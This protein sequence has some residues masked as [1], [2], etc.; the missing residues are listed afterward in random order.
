MDHERGNAGNGKP[1]VGAKRCASC[2]EEKPAT[3][4]HFN[5]KLTGLAAR[6]REC[7]SRER[8]AES[9]ARPPDEIEAEKAKRRAH[10]A[11]NADAARERDRARYQRRRQGILEDRRWR[12]HN[13]PDFRARRDAQDRARY[14]K[15]RDFLVQQI[16]EAKRKRR[17]VMTSD[18]IEAERRYFREWAARRYKTNVAVR[19][20]VSF[21]ATMNSALR[22]KLG[23]SGSK[24][25]RSW[26]GLVGYDLNALMR[27]L[28]R[29]FVPG[30]SWD[31]Y[32]EWQ[33]DHIIPVASF[34]FEGTDD[35]D[36][37]ACWS[38]TNLRPLWQADNNAKRAKRL[39][40]L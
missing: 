5:K 17:A 37:R 10:R 40:L 16:S 31:N 22:R 12:Y 27:H 38:L 11:A 23:G 20:H 2:G 8:R 35:E 6:C 24:G 19:V 13:D 30:M 21:S 32:G 34:D 3:T 33:I 39:L 4:E 36:F 18:Q 29:Q 15:K 1:A 26:V 28:E 7:R 14:E 25:G 9:A